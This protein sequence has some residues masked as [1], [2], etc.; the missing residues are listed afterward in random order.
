MSNKEKMI[1]GCLYIASDP[2]LAAERT[3]ARK[4][5]A[6]FNATSGTVLSAHTLQ[7]LTRTAKALLL[8]LCGAQASLLYCISNGQDDKMWQLL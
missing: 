1:A 2:Q 6:E 3:A 8:R 5:N 4:L 7:W